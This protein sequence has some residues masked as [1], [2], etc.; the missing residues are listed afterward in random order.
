[1]NKK[2]F[3]CVVFFLTACSSPR[4]DLTPPDFYY[5]LYLDKETGCQYES[6]ASEI[7]IKENTKTERN[8]CGT[9]PS[10]Q[11]L[12]KS[13][14]VIIVIDESTGCSFVKSN[15]VKGK[16]PRLDSMSVPICVKKNE[17]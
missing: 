9:L 6:V 2:F 13:L 17:E 1:M 12:K 15:W 10:E 8:Y 16:T 11:V 3:Y 7:Y 5:K 14:P 4:P